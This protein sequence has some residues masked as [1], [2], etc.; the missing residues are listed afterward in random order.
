MLHP[1]F[2][3][4]APGKN[5]LFTPALPVKLRLLITLLNLK[6]G[7][8]TISIV[9]DERLCKFVVVTWTEL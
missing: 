1:K 5:P 7:L 6:Q 2:H 4:R 3:T 8:Y 9:F